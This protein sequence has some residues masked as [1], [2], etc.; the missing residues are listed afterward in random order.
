MKDLWVDCKHNGNIYIYEGCDPSL[1]C[2]VIVCIS[3]VPT[4]KE[5]PFQYLKDAQDRLVE[6][7]ME[8]GYE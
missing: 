3:P 4:K 1:H 8:V 5:G 7:K 2:E 6:L